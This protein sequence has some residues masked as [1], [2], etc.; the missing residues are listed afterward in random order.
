[1]RYPATE[2]LC[3]SCQTRIAMFDG[4][5]CGVCSE[6]LELPPKH[7]CCRSCGAPHGV[8]VVRAAAFP[9]IWI[10]AKGGHND[11]EAGFGKARKTLIRA[12]GLCHFCWEHSKVDQ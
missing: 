12:D 10:K 6:E 3:D 2:R 8:L 11:D 9:V 5:Y 4:P 7:N 1:M